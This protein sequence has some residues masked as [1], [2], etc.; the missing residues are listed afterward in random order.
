MKAIRKERE[1]QGLTQVELARMSRVQ[2]SRISAI[3]TGY[4]IPYSAELERLAYALNFTGKPA[5]LLLEEV[6]N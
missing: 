2:Q 3:E 6:A 5:E 4:A 1:S